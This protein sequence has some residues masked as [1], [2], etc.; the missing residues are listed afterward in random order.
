[1]STSR[2]VRI[3]TIAGVEVRLAP[4]LAIV[5]VAL[6][7]LFSGRFRPEHGAST[8]LVMAIVFALLF[9][10]TIL[11]H[12][13]AHALEARHRGVEVHGVTLLLF[14]GVTEM[15]ARTSSPRDEFV[16]A[17]AGPYVSLVCGAA[18]ALIAT[19]APALVSGAAAPAVAEV[20]GLLGWWNVLL[21]LFNLIPGAPLDGGRV[22]RAALWWI[23][24]DR[25]RALRIAVRCG[26]LL[27]V[28]LVAV[29]VLAFT[30]LLDAPQVVERPLA[31]GAVGAGLLV[32][33]GGFLFT[34]ARRELHHAELD[35][36]L[37]GRT[38]AELLGELP[39][40]VPLGGELR[41]ADARTGLVPVVDRGVIVGVVD[42]VV[43]ASTP[44]GA[45]LVAELVEPID[46]VPSLDLT[47]DLHT[48]ID[49]FQGE[50][51]VVRLTAEGSTVGALTERDAARAIAELRRP[52]RRPRRSEEAAT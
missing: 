50:H 13:L 29:G 51:N 28:A 44:D 17:A 39:A 24:K 52:G 4:S 11:A 46:H 16:I 10:L 40:A 5:A 2:A 9:F 1:M 27:G 42:P 36:A 7:W 37:E 30:R 6:V 3:A 20:A 31:Q 41:G 34:T 19:F 33:L 49:R 15:H 25:L 26:Q 22:L 8:G 45:R 35:A 23:L 12:E 18:F 48:L 21:A 38:V 32:V 14:G 47:D 43:A